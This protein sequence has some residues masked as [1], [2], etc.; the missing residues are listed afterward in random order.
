MV[1]NVKK[2]SKNPIKTKWDFLCVHK[3]SFYMTWDCHNQNMFINIHHKIKSYCEKS[4]WSTRLKL[5]MAILTLRWCYKR[6][7]ISDH[8]NL[9]LIL[10]PVRWSWQRQKGTKSTTT[11]STLSFPA[12]HMV[13]NKIIT[14]ATN[15]ST[16][17]SPPQLHHCHKQEGGREE[18][19]QSQ[20]PKGGLQDGQLH[21]GCLHRFVIIVNRF[22]VFWR[23]KITSALLYV[24]LQ[25][26]VCKFPVCRCKESIKIS[27]SR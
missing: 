9:S 13:I 21:L 5:T 18:T 8:V 16:S 2:L 3:K 7:S 6:C 11:T 27:M 12:G 14:I 25:M 19:L 1:K 17:P 10:Q 24:K 4:K 23:E 22:V 20:L 26:W 15:K